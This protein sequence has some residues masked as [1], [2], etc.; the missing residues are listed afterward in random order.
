MATLVGY[1][2]DVYLANVAIPNYNDY[3]I[4]YRSTSDCSSVSYTIQEDG[5]L[6]V[7]ID[8]AGTSGNCF[9]RLQIN[10][11]VLF[12]QNAKENS[13]YVY[14]TSAPI[15]VRKGDTIVYSLGSGES[16]G[17]KQLLLLKQR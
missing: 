9:C 16:N 7:K 2:N 17:T 12:Q 14:Y 8:V 13:N 1:S 4:I 15:P 5:F 10:N 11:G 3:T 6:L